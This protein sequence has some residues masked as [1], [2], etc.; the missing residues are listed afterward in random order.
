MHKKIT[1]HQYN[2]MNFSPNTINLV[3]HRACRIAGFHHD[4]IIRETIRDETTEARFWLFFPGARING[5][6][7]LESTRCDNPKQRNETHD[8]LSTAA[9]IQTPQF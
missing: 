8:G 1:T 7:I 6:I 3:Y 4:I 5:Q 2:A 9:L